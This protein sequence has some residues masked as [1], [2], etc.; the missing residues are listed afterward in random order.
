MFG[1]LPPSSSETGASRAPAREAISAPVV[2]LPVKEILATPGWS[3]RASPASRSP[4][5]T[6]STPGGKPASAARC[7][8]SSTLALACS[9]G[10]TTTV[11]PAASAGASEYIVSSTG[12]FQGNDDPDD[13]E[14]LAKRV[15]EH[16]RPVERDHA[17]LDLVREPAEVVEPVRD[18]PEL[19]E[20]LLVELAVVGDLDPCDL[21]GALGDQVGPAHHQP[22]AAV[23]ESPRQASFSKAAGRRGLRGR[24][25]RRPRAR[26]SP[27]SRRSSGRARR[28]WRRR[29]RR[30]PRRRCTGRTGHADHDRRRIRSKNASRSARARPCPSMPWPQ[31]N[32]LHV[33][34]AAAAS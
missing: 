29:R 22:A 26:A 23:G 14:R 15:V 24:R 17:A 30:R 6:L 25:P 27:T 33:F 8:V 19:G 28:R 5:T 13:A 34:G 31:S 9:D 10:L 18:H 3:T 16:A 2:S 21:L 32:S 11:F 1:L 7:S 4:V 12:E 20:H